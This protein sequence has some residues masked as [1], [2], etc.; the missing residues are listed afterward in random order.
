[1]Q[2]QRINAEAAARAKRER[3]RANE[4]KTRTIQRMQLRMTAPM[5][6]GLDL[7]DKGLDMGQE[8]IFDL[9][10]QEAAQDNTLQTATSLMDA[11]DYESADEEEANETEE[12]LSDDERQE[13]RVFALEKE[14]DGLYDSYRERKSERDAKFK[15]KEAR[16]NNVERDA[17]WGGFGAEESDDV[18]E[19]EESEE[20]GWEVT[21]DAKAR[22][23]EDSSDGESDSDEAGPAT[24]KRQRD[25]IVQPSKDKK[26]AR[27]VTKLDEPRTAAELSK[28]AQVWFEQD[29][30]KEIGDLSVPSEQPAGGEDEAASEGST[31]GGDED[32]V[33]SLHPRGLCVL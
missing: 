15:V 8:D 23:G 3:R 21:A 12:E 2:L 28:A 17:E 7:E 31:T 19:G 11:E 1:M 20:G 32:K 24:K 6:I 22:A 9:E 25:D 29:M 16:K 10:T 30:F 4:I 5:D 18:D 27:L 14:M 26:R 33:R 13:R